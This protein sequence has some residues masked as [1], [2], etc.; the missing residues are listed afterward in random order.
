M[1]RVE[2][3]VWFCPICIGVE[4]NINISLSH[5]GKVYE[6]NNLKTFQ[7]SSIYIPSEYSRTL[8]PYGPNV[9]VVR[10]CTCMIPLLVRP[11]SMF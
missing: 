10:A 3:S 2:M 5:Q 9:L 4:E 8:G 11:P 1:L 6:R 7:F